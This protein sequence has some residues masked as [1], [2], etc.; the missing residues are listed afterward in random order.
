MQM[1]GFGL[2]MLLALCA[3]PPAEA[4]PEDVA[5]RY[6]KFLNQHVYGDMAE[7]WCDGVIK[8]RE[9]TEGNSNNCKKVNS[10]IRATKKQVKAVCEKAGKPLGGDIYESTK[11]FSVVTC[12]WQSGLT[13]PR[14]VYGKGVRSNRYIRIACNDGW[15]VHYDEGIIG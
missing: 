4:Q 8:Q 9:I 6:K 12:N 14:C 5:Q 1:R 2:V 7:A 11:P 10:F 15:P 3:V 13:V